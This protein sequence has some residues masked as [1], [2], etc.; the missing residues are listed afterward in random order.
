M[1][2]K[3]RPYRIAIPQAEL[4]D[5]KRRLSHIRWPEA[6]TVDNWSMGIPL[7]VTQ[8]FA[9]YWRDQYDMR[10]VE[11]RLNQYPQFMIDLGGVDIHF[12]H[13]R[14]PHENARPLLM[15]HGWPGSVIE[16]LKVIEPLTQPEKHGGSTADAY[17]L[18]IPSLPGFGFSGKPTTPDWTVEKMAAH[19]DELMLALGYHRYFA[20]GGDWGAILTTHM[21]AQNKGHC[22]AVHVNL[23]LAKPDAATMTSLTEQEM[24]AITIFKKYETEGNGYALIQGTKPQTLG[25]GLADSAVGQMAWILE[26]FY[27]WA[28]DTASPFSS[29]TYDELLDNVSLYWLGNAATSSARIYWHSFG[30]FNIDAVTMPYG[31]SIFPKE[32]F[33]PSRRWAEQTYQNIIYWNRPERGGHFAA[34]EVPELFVQE[35]RNCFAKVAL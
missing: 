31:A 32:I 6:E 28:E 14:S 35:V 21:A 7:D 18:V 19:W 3:P 24:R 8:D 4:D 11:T 34:F 25:Y 13:V 12:L 15:T 27:N 30:E 22:A 29:F 16:F 9:A 10:R 23:C 5:L 1:T 17:H 33:Q 20:Q 26:K 2:A